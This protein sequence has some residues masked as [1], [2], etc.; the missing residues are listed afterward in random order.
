MVGSGTL[1]TFSRG[2]SRSL[3]ICKEVANMIPK[4]ELEELLVN[5]FNAENNRD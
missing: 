3:E 1:E 5:F 2:S 4:N